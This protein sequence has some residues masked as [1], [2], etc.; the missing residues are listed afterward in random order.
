MVDTKVRRTGGKDYAP[1]KTLFESLRASHTLIVEITR[2][3]GYDVAF[4][5]KPIWPSKKEI[6]LSM[7]RWRDVGGGT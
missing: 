6:E 3:N 1:K 5:L 4:K 7:N 2:R